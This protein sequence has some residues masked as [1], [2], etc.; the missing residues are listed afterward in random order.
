MGRI[1]LDI[2]STSLGLNK[3]SLVPVGDADGVVGT[4]L[5]LPM[6]VIQLDGQPNSCRG[7]ESRRQAK[8]KDGET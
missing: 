8:M 7:W 1:V 4:A 2:M 3:N 6:I 5:V